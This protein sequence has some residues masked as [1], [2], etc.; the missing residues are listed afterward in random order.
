ML[1]LVKLGGSAI[2]D[3][4]VEATFREDVAQQ[5][6]QAIRRA[7]SADANLKLVIG[8]GSG[9]FGHFAAHR[10][11]TIEGV[12]TNE[13]WRGFAEVAVV[14]SELNYYIAKTFFAT[15]IPV[16]RVQPSASAISSAGDIQQMCL[17]PINRALQHGLVPL[18]YGD[19][20]FDDVLGGTILSTETIFF[21]LAQHLPVNRIFLIGDVAGVLDVDGK[22]IPEITVANF[23]KIEAAL[24]G[25][26]GVDVTGGMAAKVRDMLTLV[27]AVPTLTIRIF[28][29][30]QPGLLEAALLGKAQPGTLISDVSD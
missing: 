7:M 2:T 15:G 25:S 14:A 6:A 1:T 18:V 13:E 12:H 8:H 28:D 22:V 27:K 10:Y 30:L 19:V 16:F 21:S 3:K 4:R 9:S 11:R 17:E 5:L 24:G 29:G 26:A 20:A 23:P